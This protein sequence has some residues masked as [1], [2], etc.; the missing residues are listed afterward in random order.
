M[1]SFFNL[2]QVLKLLQGDSDVREWARQ[3]AK[4]AEHFNANGE[5]SATD[6]Q[7]FIN[8]ALLDLEDE[9]TS[10]SSVEQNVSVE[11]YLGCRWSRS[12]SFD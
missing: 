7:S 1:N 4:H 8:L 3:E 2:K 12:S 9:T 11:D 5:Q 10:T 6:I